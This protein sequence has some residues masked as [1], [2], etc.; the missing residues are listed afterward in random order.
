MYYLLKILKQDLDP[1]PYAKDNDKD[2]SKVSLQPHTKYT[3]LFKKMIKNYYFL[4]IFNTR[5]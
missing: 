5:S 3:E 2:I 1:Y 4:N